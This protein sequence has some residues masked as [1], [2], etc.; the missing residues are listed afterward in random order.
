MFRL[1]L[2]APSFGLAA[3]VRLLV[4]IQFCWREARECS[5]TKLVVSCGEESMH[6]ES[7]GTD[8]ALSL[9]L[10]VRSLASQVYLSELQSHHCTEGKMKFLL[11]YLTRLF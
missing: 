10:T 11:M 4:T 9:P 7:K 8:R 6:K 1:H 5:S 2:D 3:F